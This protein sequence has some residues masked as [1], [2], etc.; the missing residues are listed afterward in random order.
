VKPS[1]SITTLS[2]ATTHSGPVSVSLRPMISGRMPYGS[3]KA[4][5]PAPATIATTA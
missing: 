3:R 1:E 4:S 2:E 5:T